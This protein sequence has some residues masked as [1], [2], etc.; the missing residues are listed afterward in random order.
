MVKKAM[1]KDVKEVIPMSQSGLS[2]KREKIEQ[3]ELPNMPPIPESVKLAEEIINIQEDI[4]SSQ[5][6]IEVKK[7]ALI[8]LMTNES[9]LTIIVKN[10]KFSI[11]SK[12]SLNVSKCKDKITR[13]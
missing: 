11:K 12:T 6:H 9:R 7:I 10:H 1:E 3:D 8:K 13:I 2:E 4:K 5:E